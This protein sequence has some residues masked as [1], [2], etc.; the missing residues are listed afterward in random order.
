MNAVLNFTKGFRVELCDLSSGQGISLDS[1]TT[2]NASDIKLSGQIALM[3]NGL[4]IG[5]VHDE[6][7]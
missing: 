5:M 4:P 7:N 6:E 3:K 1:Q 2:E